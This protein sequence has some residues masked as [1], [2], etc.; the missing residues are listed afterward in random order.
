M[1]RLVLSGASPRGRTF[2]S[3]RA[4]RSFVEELNGEAKA[5]CLRPARA[6]CVFE[7]NAV[8]GLCA[9]RSPAQVR[10]AFSVRPVYG[11]GDESGVQKATAGWLAALP[12]FEPH[13]QVVQAHGLATGRARH[14]LTRFTRFFTVPRRKDIGSDTHRHTMA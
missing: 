12:V 11:W 10:W 8:D 3:N 7:S 13:W 14:T 5:E 9:G 2:D 4:N 6:L 1:R